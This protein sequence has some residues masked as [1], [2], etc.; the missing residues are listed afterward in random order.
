MKKMQ[1]IVIKVGSSVLQEILKNQHDY[2][3]HIVDQISHLQKTGM[4]VV[5]VSSGAVNTGRSLL[6]HPEQ[7]KQALASIGQAKLMHVW[8]ELFASKKLT[9]GQV[10]LTK[11][12]FSDEERYN[13]QDTLRNLL[14][15]KIIPV[16][17]END[18][19]ATKKNSVGDN[20]NLA[21]LV[22]NL[23]N[24]DTLILLTDQEGFYTTDPRLDPNATL[25]SDL[26][27]LDK[28][29]F[30]QASGSLS[31]FGTGGMTTKIQAAQVAL[32]SNIPTI[33][34]SSTRKNVLIDLMQGKKLGTFIH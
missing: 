32:Q 19:V 18:T 30:S 26:D 17:N 11:N 14:K 24:A 7:N 27:N 1:R 2:L 16:I 10:L 22:A 4:E 25:I 8:S 20:D 31:A 33:I 15:H 5:L 21:A 9:I 29:I 34:A 12:N 23:I 3:L 6:N 28:E 13:T